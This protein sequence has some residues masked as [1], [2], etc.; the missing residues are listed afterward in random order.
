MP[1]LAY[2]P[3]ETCK[4]VEFSESATGQFK[5]SV[6]VT[7][8]DGVVETAAHSGVLNADPELGTLRAADSVSNNYFPAAEA[9][10]GEPFTFEFPAFVYNGEEVYGWK[11]PYAVTGT[12]RYSTSSG[13]TYS[14]TGGF[15]YPPDTSTNITTDC[16]SYMLCR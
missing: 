12:Y 1:D 13:V 15:T 6:R 8:A 9:R 3:G 4:Y 5:F 14:R 7:R 10:K 11:A 2:C 16:R